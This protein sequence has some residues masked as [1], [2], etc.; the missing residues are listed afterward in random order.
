MLT[1]IITHK[2]FNFVQNEYSFK[3]IKSQDRIVYG[4][5]SGTQRR[6]SD[7]RSGTIRKGRMLAVFSDVAKE[8]RL[9]L[10]ESVSVLI[11]NNELIKFNKMLVSFDTFIA[12]LITLCCVTDATRV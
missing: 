10:L 1:R 8:I 2:T 5:R 3:L 4:G 12:V 7:L 9:N 11:V 6:I